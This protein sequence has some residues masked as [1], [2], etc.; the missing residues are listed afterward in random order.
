MI[1]DPLL[2]KIAHDV[3]LFRVTQSDEIGFGATAI[4][5]EEN[6]IQFYVE[7]ETREGSVRVYPAKYAPS[8]SGDGAESATTV[9][10][11]DGVEAGT[12]I[13]RKDDAGYFALVTLNGMDV[14]VAGTVPT[15]IERLAFITV[16]AQE[17]LGA[18]PE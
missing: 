8:R 17:L 2:E 9:V 12:T 7:T 14:L 16:S 4:R 1:G 15:P 11:L 18:Q 6:E 5:V 13:W 3:D 10:S